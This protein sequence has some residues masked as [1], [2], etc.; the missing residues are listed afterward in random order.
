ML[1][2]SACVSLLFMH[3]ITIFLVI[4]VYYLILDAVISRIFFCED[5]KSFTMPFMQSI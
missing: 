1:S 4:G 5:V 2:Y 3:F